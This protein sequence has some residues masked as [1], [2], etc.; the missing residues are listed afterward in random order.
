MNVGAERVGWPFEGRKKDEG[1]QLEGG[2]ATADPGCGTCTAASGQISVGGDGLRANA[3]VYNSMMIAREYQ[4]REKS[5]LR[6]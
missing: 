4:A 3:I 2:P 5:M 6:E 1:S